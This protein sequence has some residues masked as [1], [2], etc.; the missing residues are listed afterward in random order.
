MNQESLIEAVQFNA[1]CLCL[2]VSTYYSF[3]Y[4]FV[5]GRRFDFDLLFKK[6]TNN[7]FQQ[8]LNL[9]LICDRGQLEKSLVE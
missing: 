6:T 9:V 3:F 1:T 7:R 8:E 4:L 2:D 5:D